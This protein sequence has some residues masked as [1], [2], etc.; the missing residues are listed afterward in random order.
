M[1]QA[2]TQ[3]VIFERQLGENSQSTSWEQ[4]RLSEEGLLVKQV[5]PRVSLPVATGATCAK[6]VRAGEAGEVVEWVV[7]IW[8]RRL[9]NHEVG[10]EGYHPHPNRRRL[11][12]I[13]L[14]S[15][16]LAWTKNGLQPD[17]V[18]AFAPLLAMASV[19]WRTLAGWLD[20]EDY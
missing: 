19:G 5:G 11:S 14:R 4:W 6:A 3:A 12:P 7:W 17:L 18:F 13:H 9:S 8:R 16:N 20:K 1:D 2:R 10:L 15:R